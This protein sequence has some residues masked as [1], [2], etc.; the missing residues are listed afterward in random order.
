MPIKVEKEAEIAEGLFLEKG[1]EIEII[2][3]GNRIKERGVNRNITSTVDFIQD[4]Y[5][6]YFED[7]QIITFP[8]SDMLQID[9]YC[10]QKYNSSFYGKIKE[11]FF[12]AGFTVEKEKSVNTK[13]NFLYSL[14]LKKESKK[15]FWDEKRG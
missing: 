11:L 5:K 15:Y 10:Y 9:L 7:I 14:V 1:D 13:D 2:H 3:G 6:S 4:V 12:S 8:N